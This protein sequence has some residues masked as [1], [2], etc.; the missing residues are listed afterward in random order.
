MKRLPVKPDI[1]LGIVAGCAAML[2]AAAA[3]AQYASPP[4]AIAQSPPSSEPIVARLSVRITQLESEIRR[5]TGQNEELTHQLRQL[6]ERLEKL[7]S[8]YE[9]RLAALEG[10]AKATAPRAEPAA[11]AAP[12]G[13]PAAPAAPPS[14]GAAVSGADKGAQLLGTVRR[15]AA[16]G[17]APAQPPAASETPEQLYDRAYALLAKQRDYGAAERV[18]KTF[19]EGNPNHALTPN[20][21]YWL[22]RTYFVRGNFENAAFAFA[23][24]FQKFPKSDKAPANLLNLGMSLARLGKNREACTTYTRLLRSYTTVDDTIKRRVAREREQA[25]C[26]Q[27]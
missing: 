26:R 13:Q 24:G 4:A 1:V 6:T 17:V 12:A 5:L 2:L 25:K 11:P 10:R 18:L 16:P 8:D 23:E 21:H 9:L 7:S 14:S 27:R 22:G 3:P 20:A 19:I 15:P